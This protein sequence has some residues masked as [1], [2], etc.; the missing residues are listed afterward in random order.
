MVH[1]VKVEKVLKPVQR[2]E[3]MLRCVIMEVRCHLIQTSIH[4]SET[5]L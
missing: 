5:E 3:A 1:L 2:A 4:H